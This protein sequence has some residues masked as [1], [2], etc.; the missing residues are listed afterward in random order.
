MNP[1][2]HEGCSLLGT[3]QETAYRQCIP[4]HVSLELTLR[5]NIRCAHCYT[6]GYPK[7]P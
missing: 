4:L 1:F 7:E 5:C 2:E 3:V 6:R